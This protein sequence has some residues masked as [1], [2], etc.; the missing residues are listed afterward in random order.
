MGACCNTPFVKSEVT[1]RAS[2]LIR[3]ES[4]LDY[5]QIIAIIHAFIFFSFFLSL[6]VS[7]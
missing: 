2:S 5:A 4:I 3:K 1:P 7:F 6:Q